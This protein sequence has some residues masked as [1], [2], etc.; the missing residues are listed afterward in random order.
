[1][2]EGDHGF[3]VDALFDVLRTHDP[4]ELT[5]LSQSYPIISTLRSKLGHLGDAEPEPVSSADANGLVELASSTLKVVLARS[6][7]INKRIL[8]RLNFARY[9]SFGGSVSASI[10]SAGVLPALLKNSPR[11]AL[12]SAGIAFL[13]GLSASI[14]TFVELPTTRKDRNQSDIRADAI[15]LGVEAHSL[16]GDIDIQRALGATS[17]QQARAIA[18]QANAI[19]ARLHSIDLEM[20]MPA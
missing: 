3:E 5:R 13:A 9:V 18:E 17:A 16:A 6:A 11:F 10:G 7:E 2:S 12:I 8:R 19:A 4:Q 15:A 14:V 20:G 1:M